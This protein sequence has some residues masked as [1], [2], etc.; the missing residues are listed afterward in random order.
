MLITW[1]ESYSVGNSDIDEQHKRLIAIINDFHSR[2]VAGPEYE[3]QILPEILEDLF[4][5][6]EYHFNFEEELM[7]S[8]SFEHI[9]DHF[10]VHRTMLEKLHDMKTRLL[11][12]EMVLSIEMLI[13]LQDWLVDHILGVDMKYK[14]II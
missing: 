11:N 2:I 14:G 4:S 12:K 13:F 7:S 5:Y 1:N 6:V 3:R 9:D 8:K 10:E